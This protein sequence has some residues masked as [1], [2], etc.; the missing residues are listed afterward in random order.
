MEG[1]INGKK[2][3]NLGNYSP[4]VRESP[5]N[6]SGGVALGLACGFAPPE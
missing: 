3:T 6:G 4:M 1:L 5:R 2:L